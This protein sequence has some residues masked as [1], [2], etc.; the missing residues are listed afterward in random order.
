MNVSESL[1]K[2]MRS[3]RGTMQVEVYVS[4]DELLHELAL[5]LG[6]DQYN[7][8][9]RDGKVYCD[10][11]SHR[12]DTLTNIDPEIFNAYH[13]IRNHLIDQRRSNNE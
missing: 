3:L 11:G 12:P 10:G 7:H 2:G 1:E 8:F 6:I 5:R 13:T 9:F 4:D